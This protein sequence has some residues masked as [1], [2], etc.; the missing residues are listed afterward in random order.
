MGPKLPTVSAIV[1]SYLNYEQTIHCVHDLLRQEYPYFDVVVVDNHSPNESMERLKSAFSGNARV[2]LLQTERNSG[3]AAGN[4]YGAVWRLARGLVDYFLIANY[5]VR[6]PDSMAL[7]Q[8]VA[9]AASKADLAGVGP[10][11]LSERGFVQGPYIRPRILLRALRYLFPFFPYAYRR[12]R[13][14]LQSGDLPRRCYA[15]VGAFVLLK[16]DTFARVGMFDE[17][18]FLGAEEYIVA[19]RFRRVRMHFYFLP[20]VTIIHDRS[21]SPRVRAG[22]EIRYF[23]CG[24]ESMLYYFREYQRA[25]SILIRIFQASAKIY[26]KHLLPL[27]IRFGL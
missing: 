24:L 5:D 8:L 17:H 9:F 18:T 21:E 14:R 15:V 19:E 25:P 6:I 26:G 2:S 11:V 27:K 16:A 3:Y 1:L 22:G 12:L 23:D 7:K 13:R 20:S 10:K 4:N